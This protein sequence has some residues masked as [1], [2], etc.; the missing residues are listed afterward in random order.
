MKFR[1][2]YTTLGLLFLA[3]LFIS[4]SGGR[5]DARANAPGDNGFCGNC[6]SASPPDGSIALTGAPSSYIAGGIYP[7]TI[8]L[9]NTTALVGGFQI[10][11][12]DGSTN[13]QIGTFS[14]PGGTRTNGLGRLVQDAPQPFSGGSTS[15]T[16][17]WTAPSSGA[18]AN[19]QF[20]FAGNAANNNGGTSGDFAFS[21][22]TIVPLPVELSQY[23]VKS[24][25]E[26]EVSITW[27]TQSEQ[28][29]KHF[30]IQRSIPS[31][32]NIFESIGRVD[33]AGDTEWINNY[34]YVDKFPIW[35]KYAYYRLK[36]VDHDDTFSFSPI[37][38]IKLDRDQEFNIYPNPVIKGERLNVQLGNGQI[39]NESIRVFNTSGQVVYDS[40]NEWTDG[41]FS[42]DASNFPVGVYFV[43]IYNK[44]EMVEMKKLI[45]QE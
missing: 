17:D 18:P 28:N 8:T 2:I 4:S 12:T 3:T 43:S 25:N 29:S 19:V 24:I 13:T 38:S 20:Y 7:L 40:Q 45:V 9:T 22:T 42:I 6:H 21:G 37:E 14:T 1:F 31:D 41:S 30:E 16:F 5:N 15:W 35:N 36:Q 32:D 26:K 27:Q 39:Q 10:V 34:E 44:N 11:A 23:D 33:A